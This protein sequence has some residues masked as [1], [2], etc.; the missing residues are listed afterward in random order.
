M[1]DVIIRPYRP[2]DRTFVGRICVLTGDSGGDA[3]GRYFDDELLPA[4]YAYPYLDHSPE[5]ARVIEKDGEV[6]GY[7]VGVANMAAFTSWWKEHW[8]PQI[9]K[10]FPEDPTWTNAERRLVDLGLNPE[11]QLAPWRAEHPAD[12]HIDM[13]PVMQGMGLG[14]QL[15]SD[16]RTRLHAMGVRSLAIGVGAANRGAVGFYKRLGFHV[17][18]EQVSADGTPI[19]YTL[20]VST[21]S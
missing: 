13:L 12:F 18:R 4:I 11:K 2:Q 6:V 3:S 9:A 19:G 17:L 14:R 21:G 10:Q 7:L 8:S 20:W 16:Y 5:L 1:P 15:I